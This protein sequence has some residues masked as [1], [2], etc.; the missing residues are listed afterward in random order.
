MA[1]IIPV[2][3]S[4]VLALTPVAG[5]AQIVDLDVEAVEGEPFGVARVTAR[6]ARRGSEQSPRL[7]IEAS[8]NRAFYPADASAPPVRGLLRGILNIRPATASAYFLFR[9]G[10]PFE[11]TVSAP[12]P[13]KRIVQPKRDAVSHRRLLS[14][15]WREYQGQPG[16]LEPTGDFPPQ[17][18]NYL[19]TMLCRRLNLSEPDSS[20]GLLE[21]LFAQPELD[22]ALAPLTG[23][24]SARVEVQRQVMLG[25]F[26]EPGSGDLP[27]PDAPP[28]PLSGFPTAGAEIKIE[29]I[30]GHV[31]QECVYFRYG[32]FGN[33]TWMRETLARSA[34]DL[35]NLLAVRG[36]N[37]EL[38]E[39]MER[40][41]GL[42]ETELSKLLGPLVISDV[43]MIGADMFLREGAAMGMLF[44]ARNSML[45][46]NDLDR[47]RK[48]AMAAAP[49]GKEEQVEIAG[50]KVSYISTP[51]FSIRS[52]HAVDGDYHLVTTSKWLVRRFFEAGQGQG[53][54]GASEEFRHARSVA[55]LERGD[56][57]FVYASIAFFENVV[58]PHYRI[59]MNRRLAAVGNIELTQLAQLAARAEGRP[60]DTIAQLIEGGFLPKGFGRLPDGS[61]VL[62]GAQPLV[63]PSRVVDSLR[64]G[65]GSFTPIPDVEIAG[66]T[67]SEADDY[68]RFIERYREKV[69]CMDPLAVGVRRRLAEGGRRELVS[70]DVFVSPFTHQSIWTTLLGPPDKKRLRHVPGDL[71]SAEVNIRDHHL[72]AGLRDVRPLPSPWQVLL[73]TPKTVN[74]YLTRYMLESPADYLMGYLGTTA[75]GGDAPSGSPTRDSASPTAKASPTTAGTGAPNKA[76]MSC[77]RSNARYWN[78]WRRC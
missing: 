66:V 75:A 63:G 38:N 62:L 28:G 20:P 33:L 2:V 17:V 6:F 50:H 70:L 53:A 57:I 3:F 21:Q 43:A 56:T 55:P 74:G 49:D 7:W 35:R 77:S 59:E 14:A 73:P 69:G 10:E 68:R 76:A 67:A 36:V 39:R 11:L 24:E 31:P 18:K 19:T 27:L 60:A 4:L 8:D 1:R 78:P 15:W 52:F 51:D 22:S 40:Q 48:E 29:P 46:G 26:G 37:Y 54:L 32:S 12:R 30:A 16:L 41:L 64:G 61:R 71:I 44:E 45:L 47:Q 23:A 42:K 34:G 9:G 13:F 58:S 72:F 5:R 25:K 65:R